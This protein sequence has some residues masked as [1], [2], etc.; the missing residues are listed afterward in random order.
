MSNPRHHAADI[1]HNGSAS[2]SVRCSACSYISGPHRTEALA[3]HD[4]DEHA[5]AM[6]S[7]DD[8]E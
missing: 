3:Q 7:V 8:R 6:M 1:V 5:L 4:A 2:W